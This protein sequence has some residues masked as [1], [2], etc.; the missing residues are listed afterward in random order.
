M[1]KEIKIIFHID[2]NAFFASCAIIK[3]PYLA[4]NPFVVGRG[5]GSK[6][7]IV[8]TASYSARKHGIRS[9]MSIADAYKIYP[10]LRVVP[11]DYNLYVKNS[12]IFFKF[13]KKYTSIMI[14]GSI[15]EA[16]LDMT[17]LSKTRHPLEIAKEIQ[18][19]LNSEYKLPVSIGI[20]STLF[21][22]KMGSDMKKPLG[23]T[24]L[25]KKELVSKLFPLSIANMYGI[26][27]KTYPRL[28]EMGIITIGDFV[29]E[30]NKDKILSIMS[31]ESYNS[32]I[33][34]TMGRSNDVIDPSQYSIPKS[35]STETTLVYPRVG[36]EVLQPIIKELYEEIFDKLKK[37]AMKA[38]TFGIRLKDAE[39]NTITRSKTIIEYTD[40]FHIGY[41]IIE[42]L[43][44]ANHQNREI[45]L[46]GVYIKELI[47]IKD[48]K[49]DYNLFNYQELS[50][51]EKKY[52]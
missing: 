42:E 39:F 8:C 45:R 33:D 7:G 23:I 47:L 34:C 18:D 30:T 5:Y 26:G 13:L 27:K 46:V 10:S 43:L 21:L 9:G 22:A 35:I 32:Y 2:L 4:D 1:K 15:D 19:T 24:V 48:L 3:E 36:I 37:E 11:T 44:D 51:R 29:K 28:Q 38:R 17:E 40:D 20:S 14:A 49:D 41:E 31:L 52:L 50:A 6:R 25:R 12:E 16:Y